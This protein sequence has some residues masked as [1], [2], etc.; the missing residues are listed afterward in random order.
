[1]SSPIRLLKAVT[2]SYLISFTACNP[3]LRIY[4]CERYYEHGEVREIDVGE[5]GNTGPTAEE[6]AR[7]VSELGQAISS[8]KGESND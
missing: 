5:P 7:I 3:T 4:S 6:R 8:S 1:M 2:A